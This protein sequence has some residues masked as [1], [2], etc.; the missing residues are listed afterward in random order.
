[1]VEYFVSHNSSDSVKRYD[2]NRVVH[3]RMSPTGRGRTVSE[4]TFSTEEGAILYFNFVKDSF[5]A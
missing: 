2:N 4:H 3:R 5:N 1:M